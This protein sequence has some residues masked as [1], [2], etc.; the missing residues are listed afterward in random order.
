MP[1]LVWMTDIHL[2]ALRLDLSYFGDLLTGY[3]EDDYVLITGDIATS[4]DFPSYLTMLKNNLPSKNIFYVCGNHDYW[5]CESVAKQRKLLSSLPT[6]F[7]TTSKPVTL[8]PGVKLVGVC[9]LAD[10]RYGDYDNSTVLLNDARF[11]PDLRVP[12]HK[13]VKNAPI[14]NPFRFSNAHAMYTL[15][16]KYRPRLL[17]KMQQLADRDAKLLTTK[18]KNACTKTTKKVIIATHAPPFPVATRYGDHETEPDFLP[19]YSCKATGDVML[20]FAE[21][22]PNIEFWV[23][24]GHT[25]TYADIDIFTNLRV[26][27]GAATYGR[28][29]VQGIYEIS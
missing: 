22:Y 24:C 21:M 4:R 29:T 5:Y 10:G 1:K 23:F 3:S 16:G 28:P 12:W 20:R 7:L 26:R 17:Q 18:L 14:N 25:H 2:D 15:L 19:F 27:C 11:I 13:D 9:G 6:T 8:A